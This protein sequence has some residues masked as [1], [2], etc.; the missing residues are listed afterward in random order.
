M[1]L[2]SDLPLTA[3]L[4]QLAAMSLRYGSQ[5]LIEDAI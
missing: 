3:E 4:L 2:A 5:D 1:T